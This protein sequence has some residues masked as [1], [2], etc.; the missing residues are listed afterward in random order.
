MRK[1]FPCKKSNFLIFFTQDKS[2]K[3]FF[4]QKVKTKILKKE[5]FPQQ[6]RKTCFTNTRVSRRILLSILCLADNKLTFSY[7]EIHWGDFCLNN[8]LEKLCRM[9][10]NNLFT[11][12]EKRMHNGIQQ[13]SNPR[14]KSSGKNGN[15]FKRRTKKKNNVKI[16]TTSESTSILWRAA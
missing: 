13:N 12:R 2:K 15:T 11:P 9:N 3:F 14:I 16:E 5:H 1:H 6:T 10:C 7:R 8:H 4:Q